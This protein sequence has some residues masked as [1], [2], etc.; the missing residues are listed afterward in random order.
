MLAPRRPDIGPQ[1]VPIN[2]T[3][4]EARVRDLALDPGWRLRVEGQVSQPLSLSLDDLRALP[5]D[6]AVLPIS[7]VEGWSATGRWRGVR[8]RDL[9]AMAGASPHRG[10]TVESLQPGRSPYRRSRL[11]PR[12]IHDA[13]TLLA[14][15]LNGAALHIDHGFPLRLVAPNRPGVLQTKW[16]HRLVVG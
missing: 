3:A 2:R 9:L 8:V 12:Y 7:C 6:E 16:V 11:D 13:D 10:A 1:G 4:L 5:Q 15:E 14:L